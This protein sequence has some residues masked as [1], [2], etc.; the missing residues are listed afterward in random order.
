MKMYNK[1]IPSNGYKVVEDKIELNFKDAINYF[2]VTSKGVIKALI[3]S[4][5]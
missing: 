3:I 5:S 1:I 2:K 4:S